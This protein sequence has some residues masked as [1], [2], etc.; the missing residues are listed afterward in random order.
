MVTGEWVD[1]S[2]QLRYLNQQNYRK[3]S[4]ERIVNY[5]FYTMIFI[6]GALTGSLQ[7]IMAESLLSP[8]YFA[9]QIDLIVNFAALSIVLDLDKTVQAG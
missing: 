8:K 7:L 2:Q 5:F 1:I 3:V 6:R 9:S 4:Q